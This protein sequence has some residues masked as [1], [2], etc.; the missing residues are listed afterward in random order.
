MAAMTSGFRIGRI[1][2]DGEHVEP[3]ERTLLRHDVLDHDAL[4]RIAGA[5]AG[6]QHVAVVADGDAQIAV[7]ER[8]DVF[9]RI[10]VPDVRPDLAEHVGHEGEILRRLGIR[11]L[12][13]I[14]QD[15]P[16]HV[17]GRIEHADSALRDTRC[18]RR[19][20][21]EPPAVE[22]RIR[23]ER[24]DHLGVVADAVGAPGVDHPVRIAG[25]VQGHLRHQFRVQVVQVRQPG[26]VQRQVDARLDL[27]LEVGRR[28]YDHVEAAVARQQLGLERLVGVE[29]GDVDLDSRLF[30]EVRERVRR[31]IIG[32]DVEI[33]HLCGIRPGGAFRLFPGRLMVAAAG[34]DQGASDQGCGRPKNAHHQTLLPLWTRSAPRPKALAKIES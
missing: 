17:R 1:L 29:I 24:L 12:A 23:H 21:H 30:L 5:I 19:I 11:V 8:L 14:A 20:E 22:R 34:Q 28:G 26:L 32:P 6:L 16:G 7:G 13:E 4:V 3:D 27:P 15:R 2:G 18:D 25:V 9:R 31:K 33:Q 10:D